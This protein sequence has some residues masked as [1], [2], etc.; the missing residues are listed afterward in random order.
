MNNREITNELK[1]LKRVLCWIIFDRDAK[2]HNLSVPEEMKKEWEKD[3]WWV[4]EYLGTFGE[5]PEAKES[6]K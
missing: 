3:F 1:K 2:S 5:K 4:R 6:G